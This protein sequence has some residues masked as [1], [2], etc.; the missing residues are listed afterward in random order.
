MARQTHFV[1]SEEDIT[2]RQA[3]SRVRVAEN[4]RVVSV[5]NRKKLGREFE[6]P[7]INIFRLPVDQQNEKHSD[8]KSSFQPST[9]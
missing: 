9:N 2:M 1:L 8:S 6:Q 3:L 5:A 4:Y 7:S